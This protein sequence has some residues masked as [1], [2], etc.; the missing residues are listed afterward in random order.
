VIRLADIVVRRPSFPG[1][2]P[3]A[4]RLGVGDESFRRAM[5]ASESAGVSGRET[6]GYLRG[7]GPDTRPGLSAGMVDLSAGA[8]RL[9]ARGPF[10]LGDPGTGRCPNGNR[11]FLFRG[12]AR[13]E[14]AL[15]AVE[16]TSGT[17]LVESLTYREEGSIFRGRTFPPGWSDGGPVDRRDAPRRGE[18]PSGS[19]GGS[20]GAES[21]TSA[22]MGTAGVGGPAWPFPP[23]STASTRGDLDARVTG[24]RDAP[25]IVGT[26]HLEGGTPVVIGYN[27]IFEGSGRTRSSAAEKIVFSNIS[28]RRAGAATSTGGGEVPLKMDAGQR[29]YFSVDF[30][31][32]RYPYPEDFRPSSRGTL[33]L[34]G[35]VEDLL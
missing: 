6:R 35:P 29:L 32:M 18:S 16:E 15:R 24:S 13:I 12:R 9:P 8:V 19:P 11:R 33:E 5:C 30:L 31:D 7:R 3:R 23:C 10:S 4:A 22:W 27:Q 1:G 25:S 20:P 28:R 21:W 17:V 34:I 14:G 2:F 26:G